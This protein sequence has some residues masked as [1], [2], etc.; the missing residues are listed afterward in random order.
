MT[1]D[2]E[3]VQSIVFLVQGL[4]NYVHLLALYAC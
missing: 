1:M 2:R 3:V 4:P